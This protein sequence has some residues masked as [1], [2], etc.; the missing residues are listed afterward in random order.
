[1]WFLGLLFDPEEGDRMSLETLRC[2]CDQVKRNLRLFHPC[3]LKMV[4][5]AVKTTRSEGCDIA[6]SAVETYKHAELSNGEGQQSMGRLSTAT[7]RPQRLLT[8]K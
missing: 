5:Q 1:M 3:H 4:C 7:S 8:R 6:C 2:R